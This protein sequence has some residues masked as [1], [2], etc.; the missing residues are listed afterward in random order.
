MVRHQRHTHTHTNELVAIKSLAFPSVSRTSTPSYDLQ[1]ADAK[2]EM[3][4]RYYGSNE[5]LRQLVDWVQLA[6]WNHHLL[7]KLEKGSKSSSNSPSI[8]GTRHQHRRRER[9]RGLPCSFG[10]ICPRWIALSTGAIVVFEG[11]NGRFVEVFLQN[12]LPRSRLFAHLH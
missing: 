4:R 9:L 1:L 7:A 3:T 10:S 2:N 8:S 5:P 12:L 11:R 6:L